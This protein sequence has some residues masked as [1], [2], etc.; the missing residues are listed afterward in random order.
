MHHIVSDGWSV[1]VILRE[2]KRLYLAALRKQPS[3]LPP[4]SIQYADYAL[5]QNGSLQ[6][7]GPATHLEYWR[8]QLEA[9][10]PLSLPT[11]HPRPVEQTFRG[12]YALV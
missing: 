12:E 5:W 6:R 11:D 7:G 4:L 2:V 10:P 1:G 8:Q 3:P 9:A